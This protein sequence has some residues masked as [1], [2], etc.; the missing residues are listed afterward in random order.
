MRRAREIW[1]HLVRQFEQSGLTQEE[2]A[3]RRCIPVSTLRSWIYR[4]R[5]EE[6]E[7]P[8]LLP[9][10]VVASTPPAAGEVGGDAGGIEVAIGDDVR[11]RFTAGTPAAVI[12]ELVSLLR[13]KC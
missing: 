8:A 13:S 12:A 9:V 2:Y 7:T 10:R 6:E 1:I 4:L 3:E 5:R 11:L